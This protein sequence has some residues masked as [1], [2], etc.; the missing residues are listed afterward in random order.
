MKEK[1][2][3]EGETTKADRLRSISNIYGTFYISKSILNLKVSKLAVQS[4]IRF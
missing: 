4:I 1:L 2:F 3:E